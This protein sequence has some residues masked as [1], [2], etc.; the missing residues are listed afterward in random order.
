MGVVLSSQLSQTPQVAAV[1]EEFLAKHKA[2]QTFGVE[3]TAESQKFRRPEQAAQL[4]RIFLDVLG[5]RA[6]SGSSPRPAV[7]A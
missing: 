4:E 6:A 1:L 2:G 5:R 3:L 7:A